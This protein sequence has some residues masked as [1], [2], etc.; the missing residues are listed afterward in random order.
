MINPP[1]CITKNSKYSD[2]MDSE[3][4]QLNYHHGFIFNQASYKMYVSIYMVI[5]NPEFT[6]NSG[7]IFLLEEE[8]G[9][10]FRSSRYFRS[11]EEAERAVTNTDKGE[12]L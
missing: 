7:Y 11:A 4:V 3:E 9:S 2:V 1:D 12:T 8:A 6:Y 10:L 5:F